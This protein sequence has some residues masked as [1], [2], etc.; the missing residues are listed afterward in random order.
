M[1]QRGA[2]PGLFF[3]IMEACTDWARVYFI[4]MAQGLALHKCFP[5]T[6]TLMAYSGHVLYQP[7]TFS[8]FLV[9]TQLSRQVLG[10]LRGVVPLG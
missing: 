5:A 2:T 6:L 9:L 1:N 4:C 3:P 7:Q 8:F 10:Q